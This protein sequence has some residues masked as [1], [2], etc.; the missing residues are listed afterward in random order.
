MKELIKKILKLPVFQFMYEPVHKLYR[1]YSVPARR[2]RLKKYG[3][4]V[5]RDLANIFDRWNIP[6]FAAYGTMLG[7]VR[8][9]G[10]ISHD[11]DM[12]IGVMPGTMS[13]Q[14]VLRILLEKE[15]GFK[16]LFI[17]KY[18]ENVVE[19]KVEYR[20][21]PIDFFFYTGEKNE[22]LSPLFFYEADKT[23]PSVNANS[24]KIVHLPLFK[25]IKKIDIFGC[26][27]PVLD[28]TENALA[29]LYGEGWRVPD[30]GWNDAKRPHIVAVDDFG[31]SISL[32]EAYAL[33]K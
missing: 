13:P 30:K 23:Y 5:V 17:F 9:G 4:Q 11:D 22:V 25:G 21:I 3:P 31:Y 1:L 28:D 7:F 33:E 2:R 16:P 14:E 32:N 12:D 10:F 18:K 24:I 20:K 8:D 6:A 27:F 26:K 15:R 19:F 29:A